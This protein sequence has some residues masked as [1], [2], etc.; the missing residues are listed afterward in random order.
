[1]DGD[2]RIHNHVLALAVEE[3][4]DRRPRQEEHRREDDE[5]VARRGRQVDLLGV[6]SQEADHAGLAERQHQARERDGQNRRLEEIGNG[7]ALA[8]GSGI[9]S[10][11][12]LGLVHEARGEDG[13]RRNRNPGPEDQGVVPAATQHQAQKRPDGGGD[14]HAQAEVADPLADAVAGDDIGHDRRRGRAGN[15][16]GRAVEEADAQ[17][18][19][20]RGGGEVKGGGQDGKPHAGVEHLGQAHPSQQVAGEEA[21]DQQADD[22]HPDRRPGLAGSRLEPLGRELRD[23]DHR[24]VEIQREKQVHQRDEDEILGPEFAF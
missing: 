6:Q 5:E 3:P 22:E 8:G 14:G 21:C 12:E 17:Q 15:P 16:E 4:P 13:D 11:I 1:M 2:R 19:G 18:E 20:Q 23:H 24:E 9:R 7:E 10:R